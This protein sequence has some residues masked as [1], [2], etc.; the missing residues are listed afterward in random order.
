[1]NNM[2]KKIIAL[3]L[4]MLPLL[5]LLFGCAAPMQHNQLRF[6]VQA[7]QKD[8][9][10]EA[11]FRWKKVLKTDPDSAAAHNNLA[12]AFEKKGLWDEAEKEYQIA[13]R[14]SPNNEY[15]QANIKK[16]TKAHEDE[17]ATE[18]KKDGKK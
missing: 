7:A 15:I 13:L 8:L 16:F 5:A 12:V 17:L 14:L 9:W 11:I 4:F 3:S 18:E 1:M 10:D 2:P 6:G